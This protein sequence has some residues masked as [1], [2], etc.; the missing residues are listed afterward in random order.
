MTYIFFCP[1]G[2]QVVFISLSHWILA[3]TLFSNHFTKWWNWDPKRAIDLSK[4]TEPVGGSQERRVR[5]SIYP[6]SSKP[7]AD[8]WHVLGILTAQGDTDKQAIVS[9]LKELLPCFPHTPSCV[10]PPYSL[11]ELLVIWSTLSW[12][13]WNLEGHNLWFM[14]YVCIP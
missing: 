3:T 4:V 1:Y 13:V 2:S 5:S 10:S 8:S 9:P 11:F 14:S 7:L 6:S 12:R